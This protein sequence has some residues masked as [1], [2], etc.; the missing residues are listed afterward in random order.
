MNVTFNYSIWDQQYTLY[1]Y[2]HILAKCTYYIKK[3]SHLSTQIPFAFNVG[4]KH[5]DL[6][7]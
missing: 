2:T 4:C 5:L 6:I 1:K 3:K 7:L